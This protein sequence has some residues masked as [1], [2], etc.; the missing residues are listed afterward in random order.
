MIKVPI[1]ETCLCGFSAGDSW[2]RKQWETENECTFLDNSCS[3]AKNNTFLDHSDV[4]LPPLPVYYSLYMAVYA[5]AH[6]LQNLVDDNCPAADRNNINACISGPLLL[7]YLRN[8]SF[9]AHP[10]HFVRFDQNGDIVPRYQV[11][12]FRR[13]QDGRYSHV[14]VGMW[15]ENALTL[16]ETLLPWN[17]STAPPSVCSQPCP[18]R[19]YKIQ[20]QPPC[21]WRCQPCRNNEHLIANNTECKPCPLLSWP[22][23]DVCVPIPAEYLR[24][25]D[26]EVIL[27]VVMATAGIA[28]TL[29]VMALFFRHRK[30]KLIK[31]CSRELS[32]VM[33]VGI[34]LSFIVAVV[35][36]AEPSPVTC[37]LQHVAFPLIFTVIYAPMLV[38]AIRIHRIFSHSKTSNAPPRFI[39][40]RSQLVITSGFI[41]IQVR[42]RSLFNTRLASLSLYRFTSF[43]Y[44]GDF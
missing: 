16:D 25:S 35:I 23:E 28:S 27:V 1:G 42:M 34:C 5:F 29:S 36:L 9:E 10:G 26:T 8:V 19:H 4:I 17:A 30:S 31:S 22:E 39:S 6:A 32:V 3:V 13:G 40:P 33:A 15:E 14:P 24:W 12:T 20:L 43:L 7:A 2:L 41:V 44:M 11:Y 21:C 18:A 37:H 38:R